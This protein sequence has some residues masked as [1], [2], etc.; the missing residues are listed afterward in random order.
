VPYDERHATIERMLRII[1]ST[2]EHG[3]VINCLRCVPLL[4]QKLDEV[5]A[6]HDSERPDVD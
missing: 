5:L 2:C 3:P 4:Y 1:R 6:A